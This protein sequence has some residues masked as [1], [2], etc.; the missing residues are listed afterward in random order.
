RRVIRHTPGCEERLGRF[1]V[2]PA[3]LEGVVALAERLL[4]VLQI[5]RRT[6][7]FEE[8]RARRFAAAHD[9]LVREAHL[10]RHAQYVTIKALGAAG[11]GDVDAEMIEALELHD[12]S[13]RL[14]PSFS[15]AQAAARRTTGSS[16]ASARPSAGAARRSPRLA[17]AMAALRRS[18]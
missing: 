5:R 16:S 3:D 11:I 12:D 14:A 6:I 9:H 10:H 1:Q 7:R 4:H 2:V 13:P 8:E 18:P 17:N 15:S